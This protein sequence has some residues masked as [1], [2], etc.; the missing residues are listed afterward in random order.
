MAV[1]EARARSQIQ[2]VSNN[3]GSYGTSDVND[4]VDISAEGKMRQS[5]LVGVLA[6]AAATKVQKTVE[7]TCLSVSGSSE[8]P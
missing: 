6:C 2:M 3:P 4:L 8:K 7:G 1:M 5:M